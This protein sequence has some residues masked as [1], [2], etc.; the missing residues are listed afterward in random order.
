MK[1]NDL[2]GIIWTHCITVHDEAT[3]QTVE[4]NNNGFGDRNTIKRVCSVYGNRTVTM[5]W[6]QD[7]STCYVS[8]A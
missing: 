2:A 5:I 4:Y 6:P 7:R 1:L 3:N 8:I